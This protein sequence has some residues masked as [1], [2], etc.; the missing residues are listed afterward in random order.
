MT[1]RPCRKTT[2]FPSAPPRY[3]WPGNPGGDQLVAG[4]ITGH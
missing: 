3:G 2:F 4:R 1:I